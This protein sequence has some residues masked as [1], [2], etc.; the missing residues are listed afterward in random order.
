MTLTDGE[1]LRKAPSLPDQ[2]VEGGKRT[3]SM[4]NPD[5]KI[6]KE[7]LKIST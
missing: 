3:D 1:I 2:Q 6:L 5:L 7:I 4:S